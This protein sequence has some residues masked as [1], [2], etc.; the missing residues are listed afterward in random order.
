MK[1]TTRHLRRFIGGHDEQYSSTLL[2]WPFTASP[3]IAVP[4]I[5][6]ASSYYHGAGRKLPFLLDTENAGYASQICGHAPSPTTR[7]RPCLDIIHLAIATLSCRPVITSDYRRIA[8]AFQSMRI[9]QIDDNTSR[10]RGRD[11]TIGEH[12]H[13]ALSDMSTMRSVAFESRRIYSEILLSALM[14]P[15]SRIGALNCR[16]SSYARNRAPAWGRFLRHCGRWH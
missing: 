5:S 12:T 14:T 11:D 13:H 9:N 2:A 15:S 4:V 6:F 8:Y 16:Q 3:E 10:K 7:Y 1:K